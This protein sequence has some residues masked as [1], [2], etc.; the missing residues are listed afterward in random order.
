M[1][2]KDYNLKINVNV[3]TIISLPTHVENTSSKFKNEFFVFFFSKIGD[4]YVVNLN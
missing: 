3:L 4:Y 1:I 2:N